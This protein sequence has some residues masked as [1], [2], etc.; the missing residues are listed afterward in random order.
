MTKREL[1][2]RHW[3]GKSSAG[4]V[5]GLLLAVAMSGLFRKL[6]GVEEA[7]FSIKGQL[8]MWLIAPIWAAV[9]SFCF[10]FSSSLRAWI[11]LA[12]ANAVLWGALWAVGET[13]R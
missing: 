10:L 8:A 4:L 7:F 9:L 3:F 2:S 13:A 5:L 6:F 11:G 12:A 1:S